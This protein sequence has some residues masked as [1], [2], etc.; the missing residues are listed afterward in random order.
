MIQG[1]NS[2]LLKL[3]AL[4]TM[5]ID[6]IGMILFPEQQI[7][8]Y[9][10]RIAFPIFAY[11]IAEGYT[12]TRD[13]RKYFLKM[14]VMAIITQIP[15]IVV[16]NNWYLNILCTFTISI[17][18]LALIDK[19]S[20]KVSDNMLFKLAIIAMIYFIGNQIEESLTFKII[21]IE[22]DYGTLGALLPVLAY[23][24]R[25]KFEKIVLFTAGLL[26]VALAGHTHVQIYALI[27]VIFLMLYNGEKG[28]SSRWFKEL[29]W[30][31]YPV[32]LG[33]LYLIKNI[34]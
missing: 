31:Y 24:G 6:H 23:I 29:F 30:F 13:K 22:I 17:I 10:G 16:Q 20:D 3:I 32:H 12:Y 4:V 25:N 27:S 5:T 14:V 18:I 15:Y 9:I 21:G 7:Y 34:M 11:L 26:G 33:L 2:A 8:R 19:I 1:L 28:Y